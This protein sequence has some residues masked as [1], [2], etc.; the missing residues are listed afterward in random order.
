MSSSRQSS[1]KTTARLA[2]QDSRPQRLPGASVSSRPPGRSGKDWWKGSSSRTSWLRQSDGILVRSNERSRSEQTQPF[3]CDQVFVRGS[4]WIPQR[5]PVASDSRKHSLWVGIE[6]IGDENVGMLRS[7]AVGS[8]TVGRE[9]PQVPGHDHVR[10]AFNRRGQHMEVVG[11]RQMESG[12]TCRVSGHDGIG[13][14]PVH[15]GAGSF[16]HIRREI[17]TV[18][19]NAPYPF[20]MDG[21]AP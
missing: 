16:Q 19:Q 14:V 1:P 18:F 15:H 5:R 17:G 6:Q 10:T 9:V 21:R 20:R 2:T 11:V 13:E 3:E 4:R 8:Q 12:D 7:E